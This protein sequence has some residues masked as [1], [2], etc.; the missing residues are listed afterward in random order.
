MMPQ[1]DA[2]VPLPTL[3]MTEASSHL[4]TTST[5]WSDWRRNP[6]NYISTKNYQNAK[7]KHKVKL[8]TCFST[9]IPDQQY[10]TISEVAAD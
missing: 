6:A 5:M 7:V 3:G 9:V 10:F 8:W 4:F 1:D 2:D